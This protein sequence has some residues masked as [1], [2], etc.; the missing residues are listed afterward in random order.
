MGTDALGRDLLTRILHGARMT[1]IVSITT[2]A[3]SLLMGVT[4]GTLA[5]YIGGK[6]D[7]I[8]MR[9]TDFIYSLP[10]LLV[11]SIVA[12][13]VSK[14]TSGII[15]GLAFINWMDLAR[16]T[17]AQILSLKKEEFI[18]AAQVLGLNDLQI[19]IRHIIPNTWSVIL[20]A[21]GFIVPRAILSE[22]TLSFLGLGLSPP[23]TS[24]GTLTG[25]SWQYLRT[26]PH[27][28]FFPALFITLT[29]LSL[30]A[31]SKTDVQ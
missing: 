19:I 11:L 15:F 28:F 16:L 7:E 14:S 2:A 24:W 13:F 6:V 27:L 23:D 8:I 26:E 3:I 20:V 10:D 25:D 9:L 21:L 30:D 22:T 31:I 17:R 12:I 1:L 5:G 29:V 18:Q 4:L